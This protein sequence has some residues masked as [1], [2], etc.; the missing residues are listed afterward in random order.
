MENHLTA[1]RIA[2]LLVAENIAFEHK[3]MF[4]GDCFM[5]DDKML[6]GTYK[7]GIM[8]RV[9]PTEAE[10][11]ANR[12]GAQQMSHAG[13]LMK[14]YLFLDFEAYESEDD[15][16]FWVNKCLLYNPKAIVSKKKK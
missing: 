3:R 12:R 8:A 5:V 4:G 1:E 7:N 11:L 6:M 15:L 10:A 9:G 16:S 2:N 14:G 13:K